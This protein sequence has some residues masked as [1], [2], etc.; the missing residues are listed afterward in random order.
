[1]NPTRMTKSQ[2][3]A[4]LLLPLILFVLAGLFVVAMFVQGRPFLYRSERMQDADTPF[5][6]F[7]I[8]T[9]TPAVGSSEMALGGDQYGRVTP[10]GRVLRRTRLDELPQ[11]FNVLRGDIVFIGPRPPLRRHVEARPDEYRHLLGV[12]RPG[13][14][15]LSTVLVHRRE[16]RILSKCRSASET[17]RVYLRHCLPL[18]L[19]LDRIYAKRQGFGLDLLILWRTVLRM[20]EFTQFAPAVSVKRPFLVGLMAA[21]RFTVTD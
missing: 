4:L 8:R 10:L 19:R 2:W 11:I 18:K 14:T 20:F 1:M 3:V 17:E 6:L 7:K 12:M 13:I 21:C 9:M 15:G 16:E 5:R